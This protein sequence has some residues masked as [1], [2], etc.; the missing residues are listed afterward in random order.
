[1]TLAFLIEQLESAE[2][3]SRE[4]D[5]YIWAELD[6][7]D[8]RVNENNQV[9]AKSRVGPIH[10]ECLV[11]W[12][13]PG[14][15]QRNFTI[16][17]SSSVIAYFTSSIDDALSIS[18]DKWYGTLHRALHWNRGKGP[19][20]IAKLILLICREGLRLIQDRQAMEAETDE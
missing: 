5:A 8:I 19:E 10:D 1:M 12:I 4:L 13:D 7:W 15:Q 17:P 9:L 18:G 14:K 20:T 6:S 2:G 11:G 16:H 3:P